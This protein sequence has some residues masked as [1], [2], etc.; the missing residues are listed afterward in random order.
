MRATCVRS[1][2]GLVVVSALALCS[3]GGSGRLAPVTRIDPTATDP[4]DS[5]TVRK[6]E[7]VYAVAWQHSLDYREVVVWNAL[8]P[9]FVIYPGQQ[10]ELSG[11]AIATAEPVPYGVDEGI[12]LTMNA[13]APASET[14]PETQS[15]PAVI[16][17]PPSELDSA[18]PAP[19]SEAS[20]ET[21]SAVRFDSDAPVTAWQWPAEGKVIGRFGK[22]AGNGVSIGGRRGQ[23]IRAA[24][25]GRVVYSGGGLIGYGKLI[26]IKHNKSFLSAYAHNSEI[27][28]KE[29]D[30]VT[31]GQSIAKMGSTG[32]NRVM[33]HFEIRRDGKPVNPLRYLP[34]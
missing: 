28:V 10:L 1:A 7:T 4:V 22:S 17:P 32:T 23:L 12:S 11:P 13:A 33:L 18:V 31:G 3:C 34:K 9:P 2:L 16:S 24:S 30:T 29:G 27:L 26:I 20:S 8:Q 25:N 5:H 15:A 19:S 14:E 21:L 6:G